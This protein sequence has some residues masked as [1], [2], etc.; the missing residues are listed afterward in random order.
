VH[1]RLLPQQ[2][3]IQG[4]CSPHATRKATAGARLTNEPDSGSDTGEA[5]GA[6][7]LGTPRLLVGPSSL[8]FWDGGCSLGFEGA[9]TPGWV[10][11]VRSASTQA[12]TAGL[13]QSALTR[14][15]Q[16]TSAYL[17]AARFAFA[18]I[19]AAD[20]AG[21]LTTGALCVGG[22]SG[23][24]GAGAGA[25]AAAAGGVAFGFGAGVSAGAIFPPNG[26]EA[27]ALGGS[28]S[29]TLCI[30]AAP[31]AATGSGESAFST[32]SSRTAHSP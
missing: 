27:G 18:A 23:R 6:A 16:A 22:S 26:G 31:G 11:P 14:S 21:A 3:G 4:A 29:G 20:G 12:T 25:G 24:T 32:T 9:R 28:A 5:A 15:T 7:T 2:H 17:A 10:H 1:A 30:V 8:G 19:E 13:E